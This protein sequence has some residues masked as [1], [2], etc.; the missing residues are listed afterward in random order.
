MR[1]SNMMLGAVGLVA[2]AAVAQ[3]AVPTAMTANQPAGLRGD[4]ITYRVHLTACGAP[5]ANELVQFYDRSDAR[6][7][8]HYI[9]CGY[10]DGQGYARISYRIP[11]SPFEDNVHLL[12]QYSGNCYYSGSSA[13]TRIQIGRH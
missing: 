13:D 12:G 9:G 10:T 3:A 11:T 5:R 6:P 2:S 4:V 7:S 8:W 1:F